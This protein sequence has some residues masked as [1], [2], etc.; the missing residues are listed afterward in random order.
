MVIYVSSSFS[1]GL[2]WCIL[3]KSSA[4]SH[5][6]EWFEDQKQTIFVK[7]FIFLNEKCS[8]ISDEF[9]QPGHDL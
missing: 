4:K 8:L 2:L 3:Y 1:W 7:K 9:L 5:V 6:L